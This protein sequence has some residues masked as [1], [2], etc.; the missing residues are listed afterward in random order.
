[1][2]GQPRR[3]VRHT[4]QF[5]LGRRLMQSADGRLEK[6]RS[7]ELDHAGPFCEH[8][9]PHAARRCTARGSG[10]AVIQIGAVL[11]GKYR[12]LAKLGE[13]GKGAVY[14]AENE[15]TGK[16]VAL[17]CLHGPMTTGSSAS[18]RPPTSQMKLTA[19][20]ALVRAT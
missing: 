7:R 6:T 15:L 4:T 16:Q 14:R 5:A 20:R 18:E 11:A 2:D 10:D 3:S 8:S 13:G 17:K 19:V 12:V 1:M 9:R